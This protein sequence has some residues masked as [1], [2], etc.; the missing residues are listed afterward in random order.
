MDSTSVWRA[1]VGAA[2]QTTPLAESARVDVAVIGAGYAGT[3]AA[4]ALAEGGARV[5]VLEAGELGH[6]G[7]GLNGG[8]VIPGL[9]LDPSELLARFGRERGA[10]VIRFSMSTADVVF[11][12]VQRH[13]IDC[14]AR[15]GGW[16]QAAVAPSAMG[17]IE[18]RVAEVNVWGGDGVVLDA[19]AAQRLIGSRSGTYS[20]GWLNRRAGTVHPLNY[21]Y[22]LVRA[23]QRAGAQVCTNSRAVAIVRAGGRW[24]VATS[25]GSRLTADVVLVCANAYADGLWPGV[26]QSI[27]AANSL[28]IA[29]VPLPESA[30]SE[31]LPQGQAVSDG[32]RVMNY[33]RIGPGGRFMIGGRGP[34]GTIH[35]RHYQELVR[36]MARMFPQLHGLPI[37]YAWPGRVALTRDFLPHVHQPRPGLWLALGCNGRGVGL[38][39]TLGTALGQQLLGRGTTQPFEVSPVRPLPLHRL[40]RLYAGGLIRWFRLLDR[41]A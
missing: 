32:R 13:G 34:F 22:G 7:S 36:E 27:L 21:L 5:T 12:L 10:A 37:E 3:C 29:T 33:F 38:M 1:S 39:S 35:A 28:Q 20:G 16:V 11:D 24:E 14:G 30:R 40:H 25:L 6:G 2:P 8:Q 15:R 31:I 18:R 17:A 23:A 26:R 4:L 19:A 9:K 41:L